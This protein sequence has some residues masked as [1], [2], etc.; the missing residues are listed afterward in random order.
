MEFREVHGR[1]RTL[2]GL[3]IYEPPA[4]WVAE[5]TKTTA[6]VIASA[7]IANTVLPKE[8][9]TATE[10]RVNTGIRL[11]YE[12]KQTGDGTQSLRCGFG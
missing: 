10:S 12:P 8:T 9:R 5:Q 11:W 1:V 7:S 3:G 4:S 6:Q 2:R